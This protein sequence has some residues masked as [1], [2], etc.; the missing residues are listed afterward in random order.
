MWSMQMAEVRW[1]VYRVIVVVG[2]G[3]DVMMACWKAWR[4]SNFLSFPHALCNSFLLVT[5]EPFSL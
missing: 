3:I 2:G 1:V 4:L 5:S